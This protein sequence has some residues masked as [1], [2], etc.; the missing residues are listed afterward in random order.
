MNK[1]IKTLILKKYSTVVGEILAGG[2]KEG[3]SWRVRRKGVERSELTKS[4]KIGERRRGYTT[5][6]G[7]SS[8]LY[9]I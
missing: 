5:I 2:K 9:Y 8:Q 7:K 4:A 6:K 3:K 1:I